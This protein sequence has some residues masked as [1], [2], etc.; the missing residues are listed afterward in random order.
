MPGTKLLSSSKE[1]FS[2]NMDI[3]LA[4]GSSSL[5]QDANFYLIN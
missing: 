2:L 5:P 1:Q 4:D 3:Y